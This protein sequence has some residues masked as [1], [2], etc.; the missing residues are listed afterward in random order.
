ME[1]N[2]EYYKEVMN[3]L[4]MNIGILGN[5][6]KE[7]GV[8]LDDVDKLAKDT[9]AF[10]SERASKIEVKHTYTT[11]NIINTVIM[12]FMHSILQGQEEQISSCSSRLG[13]PKETFMAK[14]MK[15]TVD[16][17]YKHKEPGRKKE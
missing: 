8:N 4:A 2:T 16:T 11:G 6:L 10:I 12:M 7:D 13:I 15:D 5:C 17:A 1:I 3:T 14:L 9:F